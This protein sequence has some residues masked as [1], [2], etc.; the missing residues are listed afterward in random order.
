[1]GGAKIGVK[2][3]FTKIL[4]KGIIKVASMKTNINKTNLIHVILGHSY[5]FHFVFLCIGFILDT[6]YPLSFKSP[7]VAEY[8]GLVFVV[9]GTLLMTWSQQSSKKSLHER[10]ETNPSMMAFFHGPY[11]FLRSPTQIGLCMMITGL[12]LVLNAVFI[13]LTAITAFILSKFIFVKKQ[14]KVLE[15]SYGHTYKEY[16]AKVKF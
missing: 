13:T 4:L 2:N 12:G 3:L 8:I 9:L 5:L 16:K 10:H 15:S 6:L 14:E 11:S 1:M 7:Q